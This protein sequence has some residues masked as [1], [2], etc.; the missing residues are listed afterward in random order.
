MDRRPVR[1]H[2]DP[3]HL[4]ARCRRRLP[5]PGTGTR[6]RRRTRH[7]DGLW[8]LRGTRGP[9][10]GRRLRRYGPPGS[11]L[12]RPA[13]PGGRAERARRETHDPHRRGHAGT[14]RVGTRQGPVL[15]GGGVVAGPASL[16]RGPAGARGGSAG[17]DRGRHRGHGRVPGGS[18][19]RHGP[20]PGWRGHERSRDLSADVRRLGPARG[21]GGGGRRSPARDGRRRAVHGLAGG[22]AR[23][24][25]RVCSPRC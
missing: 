24:A 11:R 9:G 10:C 18:P 7:R 14:G 23:G 13:R 4:P 2:G 19:P 15:H 17:Q 3:E 1:H 20:G 25:R 12:P 21:R 16:R 5:L 6:V 22:T 8:L